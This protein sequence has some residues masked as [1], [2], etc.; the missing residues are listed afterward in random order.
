MAYGMLW[1]ILAPMLVLL[2]IF[3]PI[4]ALSTIA[5]LLPKEPTKVIRQEPA[6]NPYGV[7]R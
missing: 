7:L 6:P 3:G 1:I 4:F 5:S 2:V